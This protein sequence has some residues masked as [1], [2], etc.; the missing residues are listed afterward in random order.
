MPCTGTFTPVDQGPTV[1]GPL[2]R[3]KKQTATGGYLADGVVAPVEH[4][5]AP[6]RGLRQRAVARAEPVVVGIQDGVA[7]EAAPRAVEPARPGDAHRVF[8]VRPAAEV[9]R[10]EEVVPALPAD[11]L[12]TLHHPALPAAAGG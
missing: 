11:D 12:R 1:A 8:A 4:P 10:V 6:I 7:L 3:V 2:N 5:P 9:A